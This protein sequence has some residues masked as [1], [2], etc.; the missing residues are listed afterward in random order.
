[1]KN[2]VFTRID[3]RLIHGQVMTA[4]LGYHS[5][6]EIIIVDEDLAQDDFTS[7]I[8][9]SLVPEGIT[10]KILG[11]EAAASYLQEAEGNEKI[12]I[13]VKTPQVI[14]QLIDRSVRIDH[15]NVGG[16]GMKT[17]RS[18]LFKNITASEEEKAAF[19]QLIEAHGLDVF[20]QVVP[21]DKK[22][23]LKKYL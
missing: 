1:M 3:D 19:K 8:M 17:G 9:M 20:V 7:M 18:K 5:A 2:I 15:L 23:E 11:S 12:I 14:Q 10:L 4:W 21:Q 6:N 16:M 13:L 22:E